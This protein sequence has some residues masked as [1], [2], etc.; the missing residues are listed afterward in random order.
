M[1]DNVPE[2]AGR[3]PHQQARRASPNAGFESVAGKES[4]LIFVVDVEDGD[5]GVAH[6]LV[7]IESQGLE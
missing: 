5:H 1:I 3:I 4:T 7:V 6:G 2:D